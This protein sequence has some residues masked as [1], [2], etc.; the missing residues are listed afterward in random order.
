MAHF[1]KEKA[2]A[3]TPEWSIHLDWTE[4]GNITRLKICILYLTDPHSYCFIGKRMQKQQHYKFKL[5][6]NYNYCLVTNVTQR[7]PIDTSL[8]TGNMQYLH[9]IY[10]LHVKY[11]NRHCSYETVTH[12]G[13]L[14]A[15]ICNVISENQSSRLWLFY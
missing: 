3:T 1:S 12:T 5:I 11:V 2:Y 7:L 9:T 4:W 8:V 14:N 15:V 13:T 10:F 6:D